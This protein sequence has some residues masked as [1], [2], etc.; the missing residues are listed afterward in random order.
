MIVSILVEIVKAYYFL[1]HLRHAAEGFEARSCARVHQHERYGRLRFVF[2]LL[3]ISARLP[4]L[5]IF[6]FI[7]IMIKFFNN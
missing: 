3:V 7:I 6:N 4:G 2:L 5:H 1:L